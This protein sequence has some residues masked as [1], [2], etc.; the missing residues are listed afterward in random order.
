MA[1]ELTSKDFNF[2]FT[3]YTI[4]NPGPESSNGYIRE[5]TLDM[6]IN[7]GNYLCSALNIKAIADALTKEYAIDQQTSHQEDKTLLIV[8]RTTMTQNN[9][10]SYQ[11]TGYE[12]IYI[13]FYTSPTLQN[14]QPGT[15]VTFNVSRSNSLNPWNS[16]DYYSAT[17][18]LFMYGEELFTPGA[19]ELILVVRKPD[20]DTS[21]TS[22]QLFNAGILWNCLYLR[23][24]SGMSPKY[25]G[26]YKYNESVLID[27]ITELGYTTNNTFNQNPQSINAISG[28]Y[29]FDNE[30]DF[31]TAINQCSSAPGGATAKET[32]DDSDDDT[33]AGGGGSNDGDYS[34]S[35]GGDS[36]D[37][38]EDPGLSGLGTGFCTCYCPTETQ[39]KNLSDY[40]LSNN[41]IDAVKK[42]YA[43]PMDY[44]LGMKIVPFKPTTSGSSQVTVGGVST[45]VYMNKVSGRW[46]NIDCGTVKV[47]E[48]FGGY[49]DYSPYTKASIFLP[50]IGIKELMIDEIMGNKTDPGTV[51]VNYKVDVITGECIAEIKCHNKKGL[52]AVCYSF[53][54]N[55]ATDIPIT[56]RD[57]SKILTGFVGGVSAAAVTGISATTGNVA[58][59]VGGSIAGLNSIMQSKPQYSHSGNFSGSSGFLGNYKP[60]LIIE[61]PIQSLSA[62]FK[63]QRGYP[64]NIGKTIGEFDKFTSFNSVRLHDI[65]SYTT[66][67]NDNI[68]IQSTAT[69][70]ELDE[71]RDIL[72]EGV[73]L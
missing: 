18:I 38:S 13:N 7:K 26:Y 62:N 67:A 41:F 6:F 24:G 16:I 5:N 12:K 35:D 33:S 9:P 2:T 11:Q 61:S 64:S 73:Y 68:I 14:N 55:C 52:N 42:L 28:G 70:E 20:S 19:G 58:G 53:N 8:N 56:Q 50:F 1:I 36:V 72:K 31:V 60:Y 39:V 10:Q 54:G 66:D 48:R 44:I 29:Y 57:M 46:K 25:P 71:I 30:S 37:F 63:S 3:E 40:M 59:M 22:Q 17:P 23:S 65:Y 69:P 49:M 34:Q 45:G 47:I 27:T 43:N 4:D 51:H 15:R 32:A 21:S